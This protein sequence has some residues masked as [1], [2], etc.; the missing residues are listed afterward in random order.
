[1]SVGVNPPKTP[2]TK[3]SNSIATA[4]LPNICKM[5]GPPAPFVPTPLPNI[6]KSG[7]K[8]EGYTQNVKV[9]GQPVA[10]KGAS[11]GSMGDA[12]SKGTGGGLVSANTHGPCKFIGPGSLDV[13]FEGKNVHLLSDPMTNNCGGGGNPANAATMMGAVHA[14]IVFNQGDGDLSCPHPNMTRSNESEDVQKR[15]DLDQKIKNQEQESENLLNEALNAEASG[16]LGLME[17]KFDLAHERERSAKADA[18]EKRV[19]DET[20]AKQI[21]V[22]F[23]CPDCGMNGEIDTVTDNDIVKECKTGKPKLKQLKKI[24]SAAAVLFPGSPVHLA[25]PTGMKVGTPWPAIQR[26]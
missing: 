12:A 20:K 23:N 14:P 1:M 9:E 21:S 5:P 19:N 4:T 3:G 10:V 18:F 6:G 11:F 8:P 15:K 22:D 13:K 26:H 7:E 17:S 2:V 25:V 24:E 16:D